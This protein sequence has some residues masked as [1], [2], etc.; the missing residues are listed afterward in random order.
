MRHGTGLGKIYRTGYTPTGTLEAVRNE[1]RD[2]L[3]RAFGADGEAKR[4]RIKGLRAKMEEA[5]TENGIGRRQAE[6]FLDD[7]AAGAPAG[8]VTSS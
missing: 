4:E 6:E 1:L 2:V 7:A 3:L 8:I 5:W